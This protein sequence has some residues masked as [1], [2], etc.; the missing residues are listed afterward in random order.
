M[1]KSPLLKGIGDLYGG[2]GACRLQRGH[3]TGPGN[4]VLVPVRLQWNC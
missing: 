4:R 2:L 3:R 1:G